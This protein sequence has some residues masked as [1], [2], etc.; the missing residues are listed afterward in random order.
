MGMNVVT[1]TGR[2]CADPERKTTANGVVYCAFRLAVQ[3]RRSNASGERETDF[4]NC[5]VWRNT[6]EFLCKYTHKGD[7]LAVSGALATGTWTD[8]NNVKHVTF[9]VNADAVELIAKRGTDG[10]GE[11][12]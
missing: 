8:E 5:K 6:A 12:G 7:S 3:R 4:I 11:L 1:L 9:E 2:M 10:T